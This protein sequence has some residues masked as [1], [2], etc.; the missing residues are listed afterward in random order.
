MLLFYFNQLLKS[1]IFDWCYYRSDW[2]NPLFSVHHQGKFDI[3]HTR[4]TAFR[5]QNYNCI[6]LY[7]LCN[8]FLSTRI[9]INRSKVFCHSQKVYRMEWLDFVSPLVDFDN[10][11]VCYQ[12]IISSSLELIIRAFVKQQNPINVELT[13][14]NP[15]KIK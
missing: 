12:G 9:K 15:T 10:H 6:P 14:S 7:T 1:Q 11:C 3:S 2:K 13:V 4:S 8:L 5:T